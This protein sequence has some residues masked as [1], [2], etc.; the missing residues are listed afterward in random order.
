M[1][2][3]SHQ[4]LLTAFKGDTS[5]GQSA[6]PA[7]RS[8]LFVGLQLSV[9]MRMSFPEKKLSLSDEEIT[10]ASPWPPQRRLL[11]QI[12]SIHKRLYICTRI[13]IV[14]I[15]T[16]AQHT[17]SN[18]KRTRPLLQLNLTERKLRRTVRVHVL[19]SNLRLY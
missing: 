4:S 10:G 18:V 17:Y 1:E 15:Q 5:G 2:R 9:Q 8:N 19:F 6:P 16:H 7:R 3:S 12:Y 11:K 13:C 14:K